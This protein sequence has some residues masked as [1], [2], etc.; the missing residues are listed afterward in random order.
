MKP[1][2]ITGIGT[3][4]GKTVISAIVA[5]ALQADYW[6]PIQ[7]G[8]KDGTDAETVRDWI[9]NPVTTIHPEI[10]KFTMPASP[11]IAA[12]NENIR[13]ETGTVVSALSKLESNNRYVVIEG[14]GGIMVPLNE[15]EFV[16]DLA[17]QL[18]AP[19]ILV[20][21][22]YLGSINHSLLTAAICKQRNLPVLG[23]IF[24]DEFMQYENEIVEWSGHPL[25]WSVPFFGD[26]TSQFIEQQA[27]DLEES[28][29]EALDNYYV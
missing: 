29:N 5:Q 2:F 28:L 8:F 25:I 4:V 26:I 22:N 12:R 16:I 18:Q 9:S 1:I 14:A 23:W 6:K 17:E 21:R 7:A 27:M 19:I 24:F 3:G 11:H 20:S 13:I 10:Y 15:S